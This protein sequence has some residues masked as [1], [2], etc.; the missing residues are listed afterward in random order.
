MTELKK[1]KEFT[2][3]SIERRSEIKK[4]VYNEKLRFE[5]FD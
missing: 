3:K 4:A 2:K 1:R 5:K